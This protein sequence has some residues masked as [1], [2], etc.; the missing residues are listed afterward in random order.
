MLNNT[1]LIGRITKDPQLFESAN[2]TRFVKFTVACNRVNNETDY[3]P[4]TAFGIIAENLCK[5]KGKGDLISV[6]GRLKSSSW[7]DT[8]GNNRFSLDVIASNIQYLDSRNKTAA[9]PVSQ[10]K[11]ANRNTRARAAYVQAAPAKR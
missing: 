4:V 11:A 6:E 5:Y 10:E 7:T 8:S 9:R 3:I 2:G 1:T